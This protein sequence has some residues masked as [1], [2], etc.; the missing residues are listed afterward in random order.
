MYRILCDGFPLLD[1]RDDDLKVF[2]PKLKVEVNTVGEGSFKIYNN[3]PHFDKLKMLKSIFEV[4]DEYGVIFR[5]RMTEDSTDFNNG[6][7][8]DLEGAMAFFNDSVV[9]PYDFPNDFLDDPGYIAA[10]ESGNVI[11]FFLGWLINQHNAQ[12]DEHQ[13]F[14]LGIVTVKDKNNYLARS[15]SGYSKTWDVLKSKLFGTDI[16]GNL[17]IRYEAD[18]NYIDYLATF[19]E[20]N[21]QGVE[22][23]ENLLDLVRDLDAKATYTACIPLGMKTGDGTSKSVLT[24]KDFADGVVGDD[25]IKQG[26]MIYCKSARE[27]YGLIIAPIADTT[28]DDVTVPQNLLNKGFAY[29]MN[30]AVP[31]SESV[32]ITAADLHFT[33]AQIR[34]FRIYK[35]IPVHSA[36]HGVIDSFDLT[37]L[38][39]DILNPQNTKITV[40]ETRK[41]LTD[42]NGKLDSSIKRL[43]TSEDLKR[44][45]VETST[46]I[47][48][49]AD[50]IKQ[51][52]S[53]LYVKGNELD[54]IFAQFSIGIQTD[55]EENI[56]S[57]INASADVITLN[58]N[59]LEIQSDYFTLSADGKIT[60]IEANISG[61]IYATAGEIG[62]CS[63]VDGVLE[64]PA[65]NIK[66]KLTADKINA[67]GIVAENVQISGEI[68]ATSGT[69]GGLTI[70]ENQI[71]SGDGSLV[72]GESG[73]IVARNLEVQERFSLD[74]L[75]ANSITGWTTGVT[76]LTFDHAEEGTAVVQKTGTIT[77]S[78]SSS[79]KYRIK[80]TAS[81]PLP[82]SK[83][84]T[85]VYLLSDRTEWTVQKQMAAG[86]TTAEVYLPYEARSVY[87]VSP[88]TFTY[89]ESESTDFVG[90]RCK[91]SFSPSVTSL[92]TLGTSNRKWDTIYA[93]SSAIQTS[94]R[95]EKTDILAMPEIY[96]EVF[97]RLAPVSFMFQ[98]NK[99]GR[100]HLG[101]IAQ[102]VKQALDD[103]GIDSKDFAAYC[104]WDNGGVTGCGL[105]YEE[106]VPLN[107]YEIQKLKARV[108]QLEEKIAK[109]QTT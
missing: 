64:I 94:D 54:A 70:S 98:K 42:Y 34:S 53:G 39:I 22:Y 16:G 21:T 96:G 103:V 102:D 105:R 48:V 95:N 74:N 57:Y 83:L 106:F 101:L 23:G 82:S 45:Q 35:K 19:T 36:P 92:Y 61:T 109:E 107:I 65:A 75:Y 24:I 2:S 97:D 71:A 5:G 55:I 14:K 62:G 6:K 52:V 50:A 72:F 80:L 38:N 32:E 26:D 8:V 90:I 100:R 4:S 25:V 33:D 59:R 27:K 17:C 76:A 44:L 20:T 91:G 56:V 87:S 85:I 104:E 30:K 43:A 10:A 78:V 73:I 18:G 63:I 3:H 40:G 88:S 28:W 12:V 7:S 108:A 49:T 46:M 13:R 99:S 58:S 77:A 81:Q 89:Y 60:A 68:N 69:I 51:E 37:K 84:I 86:E 67:D 11:A 29:L 1:F 31:I 9:R 79:S 66:D 93:A 47:N 41:T 15:D